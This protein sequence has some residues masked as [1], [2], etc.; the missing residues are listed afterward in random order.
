MRIL[1]GGFEVLTSGALSSVGLDD[2]RFVVSELPPLIVVC[3][4]LPNAPEQ[5]LELEVLSGDTVAIVF[6]KPS[7]L[8]FGPETP[9]KVGTL[10]GRDLYVSF[11]VSMKGGDV[12]YALVYA[13]YLRA[14]A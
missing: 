6:K 4:V 14:G 8:E 13:F 12:G 3:R 1:T 10:E 2:F 9:V 5:S 11:R 7:G